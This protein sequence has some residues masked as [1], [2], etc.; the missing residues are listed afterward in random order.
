M[1]DHWNDPP[2]DDSMPGE[3]EDVWNILEAAGVDESV[4][5]RVAAIVTPLAEKAQRACPACEKRAYDA[6]LAAEASAA[7]WGNQPLPQSEH[8]PHGEP[9]LDCNACLMAGDLAYD[10]AREKRR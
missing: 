1:R 2:A 10:A 3:A 8:C 7:E 5:E 4:I 6:E 9:W